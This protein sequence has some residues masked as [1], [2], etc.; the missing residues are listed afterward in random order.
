MAIMKKSV[1][2]IFSK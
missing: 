1:V 2:K